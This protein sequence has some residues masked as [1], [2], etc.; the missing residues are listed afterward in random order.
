MA[1][2][3]VSTRVGIS[4]DEVQ[5]AKPVFGSLLSLIADQTNH[6][7]FA[8][9]KRQQ[10]GFINRSYPHTWAQNQLD[11]DTT[12]YNVDQISVGSTNR[13][14]TQIIR[15]NSNCRFIGF[16]CAYRTHEN[17]NRSITITAFRNPRTTQDLIDSG[18]ILS[19]A[20]GGISSTY[21]PDGSN[22]YW[23]QGMFSS[24]Y[25]LNDTSGLQT[26]YAKPIFIPLDY[27]GQEIGIKFDCVA[28]RL[29]NIC[30]YEM[31]EEVIND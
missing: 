19:I 3:P 20:N 26:I 18:C 28:T 23:G 27:R 16:I 12:A 2:I 22:N 24:G 15:T 11:F 9:I 30:L 21:D 5:I 17:G 29:D 25:D 7:A 1:I 10:I 8:K 6:Q 13:S 31:F 14:Y 4:E